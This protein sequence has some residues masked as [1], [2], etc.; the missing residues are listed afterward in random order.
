MSIFFWVYCGGFC[1]EKTLGANAID[2]KSYSYIS[3]VSDRLYSACEKLKGGQ[4]A[5]R[6][7][8]DYNNA[9][10]CGFVLFH[11]KCFDLR[12]GV[13]KKYRVKMQL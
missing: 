13:M 10:V 4:F 2:M 12:H 11:S 3:A 1:C 5:A 9:L 6:N 7:D 8:T